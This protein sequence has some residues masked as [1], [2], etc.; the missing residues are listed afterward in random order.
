PDY[1]IVGYPSEDPLHRALLSAEHTFVIM[2]TSAHPDLSWEFIRTTFR[3][4]NEQVWMYGVGKSSLKSIYDE[5]AQSMRDHLMLHFSSGRWDKMILYKPDEFEEARSQIDQTMKMMG[6]IDQYGTYEAQPPDEEQIARVRAF[7][8]AP[9]APAYEELPYEVSSIIREE[10]S[11]FIGGVGTAAD[12][13]GKI[14]SRMSIWLAE[15][16]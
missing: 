6:L 9:V 16:H 15:N 3:S 7:L 12:C 1:V 13:A 11:S 8:D 4:P 14:Q 2:K 5:E 10:I